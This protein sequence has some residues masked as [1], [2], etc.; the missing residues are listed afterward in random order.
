M[1]EGRTYN[2]EVLVSQTPV[3]GSGY[4]KTGGWRGWSHLSHVARILR[5]ADRSNG[6][7]GTYLGEFLAEHGEEQIAPLRF[8]GGDA[9]GRGR[10]III[11]DLEKVRNK[12]ENALSKTKNVEA[13]LRCACELNVKV[14]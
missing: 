6:E 12:V 8:E 4:F 3:K 1:E 11:L 10:G 14:E 5:K 7:G 9:F 2:Y 13:L